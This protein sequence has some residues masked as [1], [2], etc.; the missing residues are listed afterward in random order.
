MSSSKS[1]LRGRVW[2]VVVVAVK[3]GLVQTKSPLR[4]EGEMRRLFD[5]Y[6]VKGHSKLAFS[7]LHHIKKAKHHKHH[8][9]SHI[10]EHLDKALSID[11]KQECVPPDHVEENLQAIAA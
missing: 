7:I 5:K 9:H 2:P 4:F 6:T 8:Y 10:Q 3:R 11:L 1:K